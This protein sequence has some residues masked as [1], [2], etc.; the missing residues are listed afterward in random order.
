ME[1]AKHKYTLGLARTE[2]DALPAEICEQLDTQRQGR[3]AETLEWIGSQV[4][5]RS[6]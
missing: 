4:A 2:S 5:S 3:D 1:R 6:R